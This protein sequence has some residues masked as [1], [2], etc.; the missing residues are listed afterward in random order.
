MRA[1]GSG[2]VDYTTCVRLQ[3]LQPRDVGLQGG[4]FGMVKASSHDLTE[5]SLSDE[6]LPGGSGGLSKWVNYGDNW[7]IIWLIGVINLLTKSP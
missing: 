5:P 3:D 2:F 4:S 6:G 7:V 1:Q